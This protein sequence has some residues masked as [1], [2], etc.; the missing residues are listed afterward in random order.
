MED[1]PEIPE[2]ILA[3]LE[4]QFPDRAPNGDE[5][6]RQVW[7]TTGEVRVIRFLRATFDRQNETILGDTDV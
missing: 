6:D 4:K 2:S 7:I 1:F 3:A 5:T